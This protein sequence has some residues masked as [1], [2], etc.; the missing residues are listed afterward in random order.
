LSEEIKAHKND[1]NQYYQ[2]I[3]QA[4]QKVELRQKETIIQLDELSD[5]LQNNDEEALAVALVSVTDTIEDF[6]RLTTDDTSL[7]AQS[8]K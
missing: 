3:F 7:L 1:T 4:L 8:Q 6:Y 5:C 2:Q